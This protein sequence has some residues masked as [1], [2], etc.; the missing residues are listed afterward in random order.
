[1]LSRSSKPGA[2]NCWVVARPHVFQIPRPEVNR[3]TPSSLSARRL[4]SA[5]RTCNSTCWL[6]L[7]PGTCSML[8]TARSVADA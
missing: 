5:N 1:M 3:D 2:E 6:S 8:I 4:T 7:P